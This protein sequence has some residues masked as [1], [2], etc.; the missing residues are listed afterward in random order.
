[1]D[2]VGFYFGTLT[3]A[4]PADTYVFTVT[5]GGQSFSATFAKSAF[6]AQFSGRGMS[7]A[8]ADYDADGFTD[9][10]VINDNLPNFLF[11]NRGNGTFKEVAVEL[12]IGVRVGS[13][14]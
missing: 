1:M 11:H 10:F 4:W 9:I 13:L 2:A 5:A 6:V 7:V 14:R 12:G 8:F 3:S